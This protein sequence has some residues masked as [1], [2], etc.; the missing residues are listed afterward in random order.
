VID[1][2]VTKL[3]RTPDRAEQRAITKKV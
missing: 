1:E 3:R 2:L